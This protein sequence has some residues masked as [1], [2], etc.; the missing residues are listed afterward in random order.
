MN[1][2]CGNPP[3]TA[4]LAG[5]MEPCNGGSLKTDDFP[6]YAL[7]FIIIECV[8]YVNPNSG[9]LTR[10]CSWYIGIMEIQGGAKTINGINYAFC[11]TDG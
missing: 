7:I 4:A 6:F 8:V 10:T 1:P 11:N 9:L 5:N 3:N 2:A